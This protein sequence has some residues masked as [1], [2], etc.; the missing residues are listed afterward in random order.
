[1]RTWNQSDR[2]VRTRRDRAL[3]RPLLRRSRPER[4]GLPPR[5][6]VVARLAEIAAAEEAHRRR[7][8]DGKCTLPEDSRLLAA[9]QH[10]LPPC[11]GCALGF[12]R[13]VMLACGTTEIRDVV[14]FT[15]DE[16]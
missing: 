11:S 8:T 4:L 9:M 7:A 14:A 16:L 15:W 10:S 1:M 2:R 5:D 13:L 3:R 6:D 12:D